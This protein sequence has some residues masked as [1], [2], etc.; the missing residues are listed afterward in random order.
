M[1]NQSP[2]DWPRDTTPGIAPGHH[3]TLVATADCKS[4]PQSF[5]VLLTTTVGDQ[6]TF[7]VQV[8]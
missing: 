3:D 5:A 7:I 6:Y 8:Q 4:P 2:V 1:N